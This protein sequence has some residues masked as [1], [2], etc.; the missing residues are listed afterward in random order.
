M[1]FKVSFVG[2]LFIYCTLLIVHIHTLNKY[3]Y[4]SNNN[5][6]INNNNNN[7]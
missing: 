5:S 6:K 7:N 2:G 1:C 4:Q 3:L